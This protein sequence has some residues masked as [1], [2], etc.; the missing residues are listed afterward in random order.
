MCYTLLR[1]IELDSS[2]L[3]ANSKAIIRE[4]DEASG[5]RFDQKEVIRRLHETFVNINVGTEDALLK[6]AKSLEAKLAEKGM[7]DN[8][9]V[10]SLY[11]RAKD[12]GPALPFTILTEQGEPIT[13]SVRRYDVGFRYSKNTAPK[14]RKLLKEFLESFGIGTAYE[15]DC[16]TLGEKQSPR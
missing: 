14:V 9:L 12:L 5:L 11:Q 7:I 10:R 3:S 8:R 16:S 2:S 6:K 15:L 4:H 1:I 13:G